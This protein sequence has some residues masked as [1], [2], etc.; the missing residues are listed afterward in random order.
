MNLFP[1]VNGP[2]KL[3]EQTASFPLPLPFAGSCPAA[4]QFPLTASDT[5]VLTFEEDASLP[6]EGYTLCIQPGGI[7]LRSSGEAGKYYG[8][9]TLFQLPE[10]PAAGGQ[11]VL[12]CGKID[13]A[14]RYG[15][16]GFMWDVSRHFFGAAEVKKVLDQMARLKMNVFHWHLSDDQGF[17]IESKKFPRLNEVGSQRP[18]EAGSGYYTQEEI[19]DIVSYAAARHIEIIP[20]IDLPGH[21]T[22][23]IAAYPELSCSGEPAEVA[24]QGGVYT[25][26]LCAGNEKVYDFLYEL[27]DEVLSLFPGPYFHIGGD[28]APKHEWK[29]CPKCQAKMAQL[30]LGSEE[31]LQA[32][33]TVQLVDYLKSKGKTTIGWN[34]MLTS[35]KL[36]PGAVAQYWKELGPCYSYPE[37][38]KGRRF[39]FS[40][41]EEFYFDYP[42]A[43]VSLMAT[44]LYEPHMQ[45]HTD[46]PAEQILGLEAPL[47]CERVP[48]IQTAHRQIFPRMLAIAENAWTLPQH[49]DYDEF[50][51]R[52]EAYEPQW[53]ARGFA[54]TPAAEADIHGEAGIQFIVGM[55][56]AMTDSMTTMASLPPDMLEMYMNM[57]QNMIMTMM[58]YRYT[59]EERQHVQNLL[60]DILR[61]AR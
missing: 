17:R 47:W 25:R 39:I 56:H 10:A 34:E 7:T 58:S 52:A 46:I 8:L 55:I 2:A 15:H 42:Y 1:K 44:Y 50:L 13:D 3:T 45:E 53:Q 24:T 22:A 12:P 9:Q 28:E 20:E 51:K 6:A 38:A 19:R 27:L 31:E 60:Q 57:A 36:E 48:D 5:P 30:G 11:L 4:D 33:F 59:P 18:D 29:Q 49:K 21:T 61:S 37:L 16:R 43:M 26:I 40:N 32:W 54:Y 23:I 14:P 35:G 41:N